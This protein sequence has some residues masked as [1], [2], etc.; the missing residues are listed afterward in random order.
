MKL[1][2]LTG[3]CL[4]NIKALQNKLFLHLIK[5]QGTILTTI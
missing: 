1:F 3:F 2:S 4:S 5:D